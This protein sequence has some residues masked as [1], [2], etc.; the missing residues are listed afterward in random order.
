MLKVLIKLQV[1]YFICTFA[2][3]FLDNRPANR[4]TVAAIQKKV[5]INESSNLNK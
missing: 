2:V 1:S 3:G 4:Y 5:G